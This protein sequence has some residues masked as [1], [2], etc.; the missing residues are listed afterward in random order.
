MYLMDMRNKYNRLNQKTH[1]KYLYHEN[2]IDH[3]IEVLQ[4]LED[5]IANEWDEVYQED[6]KESNIK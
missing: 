5:N 6:L 4:N 3:E 1:Y 2:A